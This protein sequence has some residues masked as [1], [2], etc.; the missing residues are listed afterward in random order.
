MSSALKRAVMTNI[1]SH[2][3][4]VL[5][6]PQVGI[7]RFSGDNSHGKSVFVKVLHDV[8]SNEISRPSNR[9]S[10]IRRGH[11]YGELLLERWDGMSLFVNIHL[12]AAHTY[13]E[14][15]RPGDDRP[16]RRYLSDKSIPLLVKEFGWHYDAN[17]GVSINIHGDTDGLLFVDTKKSVNFELLNS[18]RSDAFAEAAVE[19]LN[20]LIKLTKVKRDEMQHAFDVA[21]ATYCSLQYWDIQK[22]EETLD[23]A[24][25][26]ADVLD[27]LTLSPLPKFELRRPPRLYALVPKVPVMKMPHLIAPL[28]PIPKDASQAIADVV[29]LLN[30]I[31]PTCERPLYEGG[32]NLHEMVQ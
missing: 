4:T 24:I 12:E 7:V 9:R 28:S 30:G 2:V 26:W 22:E 16:V 10:I 1:Q 29:H 5:E 20:K 8:I 3:S 6:F 18:M 27:N 23:A 21:Q 31:C 11:S 14:L 17:L 13:A 15:T 19:E 25:Y 32:H